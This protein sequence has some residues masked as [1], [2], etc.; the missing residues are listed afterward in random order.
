MIILL[1]T[2][3]DYGLVYQT[4]NFAV[5]YLDLLYLGGIP[6]RLVGGSLTRLGPLGG[7]RVPGSDIFIVLRRVP[8]RVGIF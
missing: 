5:L 2:L 8:G 4:R 6:G 3:H 1:G 7:A